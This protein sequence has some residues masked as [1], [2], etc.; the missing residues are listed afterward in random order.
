MTHPAARPTQAN[1][2]PQQQWHA[3]TQDIDALLILHRVHLLCKDSSSAL[4]WGAFQ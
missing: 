2:R 3:Q 4:E 1:G